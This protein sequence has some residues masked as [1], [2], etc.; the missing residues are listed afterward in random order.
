MIIIFDLDY[1][2]LD[3]KKFK[4]KLGVALDMS[5]EE[6]ARDYKNFFKDKK[7]NYNPER[8]L[9]IL[10]KEGR[11]LPPNAKKESPVF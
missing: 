11:R 9:A 8:H 10:K 2:L 1:T 7:I 3:T 5:P 4:E 6:W